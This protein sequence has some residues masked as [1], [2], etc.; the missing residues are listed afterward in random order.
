MR[1]WLVSLALAVV[2]LP[3]PGGAENLRVDVTS[4]KVTTSTA[5]LRDDCASLS[6]PVSAA[7]ELHLD[8]LTIQVGA[9]KVRHS[10][11]RDLH[12]IRQSGPR[13]V[14]GYDDTI[15][16]ID[17]ATGAVSWRRKLA[18]TDGADLAGGWL[19]V[20]GTD[21]LAILDARTGRTVDTSP[22]VAGAFTTV[23]RSGAGDIYIK[24]GS[25]LIAVARATGAVL[26]TQS[27]TSPGNAAALV[28]TV[29]DGWIDMHANRFGIITYDAASG[30]KLDS[31][32]LGTTGGWYDYQQLGIAPDGDHEV[33]V[34][35]AFGVE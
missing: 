14:V 16:A 27:S 25:N 22:L 35:A 4:H 19:A 26:W 13:V 2:V 17:V 15:V 3:T 20:A 12:W 7:V 18:S 10:I 8:S 34:S 31:I 28:G 6:A 33:L 24:T 5:D 11:G 1:R 30:R 23:C 21:Q 32:D 9:R 29:V